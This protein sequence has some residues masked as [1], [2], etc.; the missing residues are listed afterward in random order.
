MLKVLFTTL[1]EGIAPPPGSQRLSWS[2]ARQSPF[3]TESLIG[4]HDD[5]AHHVVVGVELCR[6]AEF[7][8]LEQR[9]DMPQLRMGGLGALAHVVAHVV[10]DVRTGQPQR[11][12]PRLAQ[13]Q[14]VVGVRQ[15]LQADRQVHAMRGAAADLGV[16]RLASQAHVHGGLRGRR[17]LGD[18]VQDHLVGR[19]GRTE[20]AVARP[21]QAAALRRAASRPER[22]AG[23]EEA[24]EARVV[25][26]VAAHLVRRIGNAGGVAFIG[27]HEQQARGFQRV[28]GQHEMPAGG[29]VRLARLVVPVHGGDAIVLVRVDLVDHGLRQHDGALLLGRLDMMDAVVHGADRTDRLTIVVAATGGTAAPGPRAAALRNGHRAVAMRVHHVGETLVAIGPRHHVHRIGTAALDRRLLRGIVGTGHA[30]LVLGLQVVGL[31]LLV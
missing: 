31:Q 13:G 29:L 14:A 7:G 3:T 8:G 23:Q 15:R 18:V 28:A 22:F 9:A 17:D 27:G 2:C 30:H 1:A 12:H 11:I 6:D 25:H 20:G 19:I 5:A 16:Q 26:D 10:V 21:H 4:A 24:M